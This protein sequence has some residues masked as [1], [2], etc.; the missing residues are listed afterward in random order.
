MGNYALTISGSDKLT[1]ESIEGYLEQNEFADISWA[2]LKF[3]GFSD[4]YAALVHD[5]SAY[6]SLQYVWLDNTRYENLSA[7]YTRVEYIESNGSQMVSC[8][9]YGEAGLE[10]WADI[11]FTDLTQ[12][13]GL[14]IG[15]ADG[16]NPTMYIYRLTQN[17][18]APRFFGNNYP[19]SY[20]VTQNQKEH[21][22]AK[23]Y[24]GEQIVQ[25]D[26]NTFINTTITAT[27][28]VNSY[29]GVFAANLN[30][31][32]YYPVNGMRLYDFSIALNG[33][34]VNILVPCYR[35][36]DGEIGLYDLV[37]GTFKTNEG[38]GSFT[39]GSDLATPLFGNSN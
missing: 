19:G 25:V 10:V 15:C 34:Y 2:T 39:K 21:Y 6:P 27:A 17:I 8:G 35:I 24:D 31:S 5:Y 38:T 3:V 4:A 28:T 23:L 7:T 11:A 30:G 1:D 9:V 18:N 20:T 13:T 29:V 16:V 26:G 14:A 36:S 33:N 12:I 22:Y 37:T 32:P